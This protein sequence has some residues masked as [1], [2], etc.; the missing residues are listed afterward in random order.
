[1]DSIS[2]DV[3]AILKTPM[4]IW[5]VEFGDEFAPEFRALQ[6]AVRVE[7]LALAHL[8]QRFGPNLKRPYADTLHGSRQN[9][10]KELRFSAANGEWPS[11]L[12]LTARR[13][14]SLRETNPEAVKNG[15]IAS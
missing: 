2:Y 14:C 1:M 6:V 15:S 4:T 11:R 13:F 9:N 8:L 5:T 12:I 3:Y 7:I 10:M